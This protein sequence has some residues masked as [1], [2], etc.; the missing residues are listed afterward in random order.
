MNLLKSNER[1]APYG[2][3]ALKIAVECAVYFATSDQAPRRGTASDV[4][5]LGAASR[6]KGE[7]RAARR[8]RLRPAPSP[9]PG[10]FTIGL[11]RPGER[12]NIPMAAVAFDIAIYS[13]ILEGKEL[14]V[15]LKDISSKPSEDIEGIV[16]W[17]GISKMI[18]SSFIT[19]TPF[20]R[21]ATSP[22]V[23]LFFTDIGFLR[24]MISK[25]AG[26]VLESDARGFLAENF[27][28]LALRDLKHLF[29]DK[30]VWKYNSKG[31]NGIYEES[32][33]IKFALG[34][35]K[36]ILIE[37]K[38]KRGAT[39]TADKVLARGEADYIVKIADAEA[40]IGDTS[41]VLP[42]YAMDRLAAIVEMLEAGKIGLKTRRIEFFDYCLEESALPDE[43][44]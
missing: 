6:K 19:T 7:A 43:E 23:K 25:T 39:P 34:G 13:N 26:F 18:D 16:K 21:E 1:D 32:D 2:S 15:S 38:D 42:F 44:L 10:S 29:S 11:R 28:F 35:R 4:A 17:F 24:Y 14:P 20:L 31:L 33:F 40:K 12:Q 5:G 22:Y 27:V 8:L 41:A 3:I 9:P 36:R 37:V 30:S